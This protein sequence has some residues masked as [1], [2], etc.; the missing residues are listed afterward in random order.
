[1]EFAMENPVIS[2]RVH[3]RALDVGRWR[4]DLVYQSGTVAAGYADN[5]DEVHQLAHDHG[6][7]RD[8]IVFHGDAYHQL[9]G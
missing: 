4:V 5:L 7:D 2:V 8:D 9:R 6:I 3:E 1:M